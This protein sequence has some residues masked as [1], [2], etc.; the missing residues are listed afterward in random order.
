MAALLSEKSAVIGITKLEKKKFK[1]ATKDALL[2]YRHQLDKNQ[3]RNARGPRRTLTRAI[4]FYLHA[5]R[6]KATN[7]QIAVSKKDLAS[8]EKFV[9]Q[10]RR[11]FLPGCPLRD[12]ALFYGAHGD[13]LTRK[14]QYEEGV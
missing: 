8:V 9:Q 13:L 14:G 1:K 5:T 4:F 3:N 12:K 11:R 7:L 10:F 6:D 2:H